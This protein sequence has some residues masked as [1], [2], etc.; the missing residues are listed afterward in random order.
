[1]I[2]QMRTPNLTAEEVFN[3]TRLGVSRA[4]NYEQTPWVASSLIEAFSFGTTPQV[5]AAPTF[6]PAPAPTPAPRPAP[7][8]S[9]APAPPTAAQPAPSQPPA[10]AGTL[11]P[12]TVPFIADR[13]RESIRSEYLPAPDHK[14]L[15]ISFNRAGFTTGQADDETAKAAALDNC[16]SATE[17]AGSKNQC[18]LYA[19]GN[20]VVF[21][22][23]PPMPPPPWLVRNPTV[24]RPFVSKDLPL[25]N[26]NARAFWDKNYPKARKTKALAVAPQGEAFDFTGIDTADE[27]IRRA[28]ESCGYAAGVPCMVVA[29]DD[30]F[31]VPI[32]TTMKAVGI[33]HPSSNSRITP[34]LREPL[35]QRL[36]NA[37]NAWN[38]VAVGA[39][40]RLGLKLNAAGEQDAITGALSDCGRQDT[41]CRV[42]AL[43]PF[44]VE[45]APA[46]ADPGTTSK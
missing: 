6:T 1:L 23:V 27:A 25:V 21:K 10:T 15:A 5:A 45:P 32:P 33:F 7:A 14:A 42:V 28:L 38:A 40:G 34:E 31:V 37:T 30:T 18:Q 16:K 41:E 39:A 24:E 8:P 22:G 43:G 36:A 3:R 26:D 2:N 29:V 17:A 20:T 13:A 35:A 44:T 46:P 19:V 9:P 12:E 11:V 4:S